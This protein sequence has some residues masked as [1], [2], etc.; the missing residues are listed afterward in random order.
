MNNSSK[1]IFSLDGLRAISIFLVVFSHFL[2]VSGYGDIGNLGNLGVR[3]FFV[4][5]GFLITGLLL[6]ELERD[7]K[8]NLVKFYF[9]RTLRI[10]PP[11]YFF[12]LVIAILT[13]AG[14]FEIDFKSFLYSA[15]YTIN[16][17][18]TNSADGH[19]LGHTWS[20]A[21]EEQF[22]L[23]FPTVFVFL[24]ARKT[25]FFL[26]FI[27]LVSPFI[28]VL[29]YKI[30][31]SDFVWAFT[32][33]HSNVDALSSG[34]LLAFFHN[35]L[36][37]NRLYQKIINSKLAL[38]FPVVTVLFNSTV[39]HPLIYFGASISAMNLL[40]AITIDA[41]VTNYD[42]L[43]GKF[44]NSPIPTTI[45]VM[46]YSIYLWQQPFFMTHGKFFFTQTPYNL[47]GLA[48]MTLISF[49]AVEKYSL[50]ARKKLEERFF[51]EDTE[52]PI[53]LQTL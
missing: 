25:K 53:V 38:I 5:S 21:V 44:L 30:F 43:A 13:F 50:V 27:I 45:G 34:C 41:A 37:R 49:Y 3:V 17:F 48:I 11:F 51:A 22:Y 6:K 8:I 20:L 47:V 18:G 52:S 19:N 2:I 46:S 10:F 23:I 32:A 31:G 14:I 15:T 42:S 4:I 26:I 16:Y 35:D 28:R 12:L 1:R 36:H 33:F 24:G 7:A 9:R 40:I 29:D 39:E